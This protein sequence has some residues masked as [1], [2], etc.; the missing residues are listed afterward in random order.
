[1]KEIF[2]HYVWE[3]SLFNTTKLKTTE[4]KEIF[5]FDA[6]K[7]LHT[8]GP[9]F[10]NAKLEIQG[11][12]WAGNVE[13]HVNAS[14]W[15]LHDHQED[16]AYDSVILHVVWDCDVAVF[17]GDNSEV[18]TLELKGL[19][20]RVLYDNY[21]ELMHS[22]AW[23]PCENSI[24]KVDGFLLKNWMER[25]YFE[26]LEQKSV[27][28]QNE[29]ETTNSDWEAVLFI[30]LAKNFGLKSNGLAMYDL[31]RS[32]GFSV[33]RK[34]SGNQLALESLFYGQA[35]LLN[36]DVDDL[37][38]KELRQ[39]YLFCKNKYNLN[40]FIGSPLA[41]FGMR[42]QNFPTIRIS[43]FCTLY[44]K[45]QQL[46]SELMAVKDIKGIYKILGSNTSEY[47]ERHYTFG[48]QTGKK[49]KS[50][51]K[52]FIDLLIINTIIPVKISY[53][54]QLGTFNS[55]EIIALVSQ[56][57]PEKN[58]IISKFRSCDLLVGNALESQA[59]IQ[60]KNEYCDA[61]KCLN[62]AIGND[63]LKNA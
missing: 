40:G 23:I 27:L 52:D 36:I 17:R 43:Q 13:I 7:K 22:H 54:K 44:H 12:I 48:K 2:L 28:V 63:L 57:K 47:W 37:Y 19:I 16:K 3:Y 4:G 24:G 53:L 59:L 18:P 5:I 26:R 60:L 62:C 14:D 49:R 25:M 8:S 11:Q 39:H 10:F 46:F 33:F 6:G 1:M 51:T 42:P 38:Y 21:E 34:E 45:K 50:L 61:K 29:L 58:S 15:Y 56:I 9:D 20:P 55:E 31:A 41:F 30:L 35:N 32:I